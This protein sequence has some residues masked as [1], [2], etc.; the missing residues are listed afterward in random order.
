MELLRQPIATLERLR[1]SLALSDSMGPAT[2]FSAIAD[3]WQAVLESELTVLEERA[4]A[5]VEIPQEYIAGPP[6]DARTSGRRFRGRD[7]LFREIEQLALYS[8]PPV[9]LLYGQR[10][11]GKTSTLMHLPKRVAPE[12]VPLLV[13][14]QGLATTASLEGLAWGLADQIVESARRA[15][16][17]RLPHPDSEAIRRDPVAGLQRWM[18]RLE[19]IAEGRTLLLCLDEFE[20]LGEIIEVTGSRAPL[21]LLRYL[22][23]HRL[24][25]QLLFSGAHAPDELD[26]YWSDYL[27]NTRTLHISYLDERDARGLIRHPTEDFPD[28]YQPETVNR[29]VNLSRCQPFLVQLLCYEIV[30]RLNAQDRW[31]A[32]PDDVEA[33]VPIVFERGGQYFGWLWETTSLE[34]HKV[35]QALVH[36][37]QPHNISPLMLRSLVRREILEKDN[38]T[39]H[40]QVPLIQR[41]VATITEE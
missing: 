9:L 31:E 35:L 27:I 8:T 10:R 3:R 2:T 11:T 24:Q 33:V 16:N 29:I 26:D 21:N 36:G 7:D 22:M 32:T 25:W 41:Y 37:K 4:A 12:L 1:R 18:R 28:I 40:F 19:R 13:A 14:V 39:Y 6:L 17:M 38:G 30:E 15:R 5:S 34:G 20:R 23:E